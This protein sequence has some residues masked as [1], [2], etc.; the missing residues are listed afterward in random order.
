MRKNGVICEFIAL[1]SENMVTWLTED[2]LKK[3]QE[4][5][6]SRRTTVRQEIAHA[7]KE[8]KEQGD[9]SENAEYSAARQRQGENE[10]R[11]TELEI[12]VKNAR[13]AEKKG[14]SNKVQFGSCVSIRTGNNVMKFEIVG[15]NEVDPAKGKISDQSP[16]GRAFMG[17]EK[18][19]NVIVETPS[20][21]TDFEIL[22]IE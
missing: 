15:T 1:K 10:S 4:E 21:K 16:M 18:G 12:L 7:I 5:L 9:L 3:I 19:D 17:K 20:G 8:A 6:E 14:G 2:G 22:E 11:I 13:V